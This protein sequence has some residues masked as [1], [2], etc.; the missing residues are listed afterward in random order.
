[1]TVIVTVRVPMIMIVRMP[2][3]LRRLEHTLH[4]VVVDVLAIQHLLNR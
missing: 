3:L 1:M 4:A 2:T